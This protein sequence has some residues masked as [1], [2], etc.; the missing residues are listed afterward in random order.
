MR[1]TRQP[2]VRFAMC[3]LIDQIIPIVV[4][5]GQQSERNVQSGGQRGRHVRVHSLNSH[6]GVGVAV[7]AVVGAAAHLGDEGRPRL[8]DGGENASAEVPPPLPGA[9]ADS[10]GPLI[11]LKKST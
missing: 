10:R 9:G 6:S 7:G 3:Y 11:P 2:Y 4:V 5:I 8:A 1:E